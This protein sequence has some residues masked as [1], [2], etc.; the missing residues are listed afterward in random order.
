M[1]EEINTEDLINTI[2]ALGRDWGVEA[3]DLRNFRRWYRFYQ[4]LE[5]PEL[6]SEGETD[7]LVQD[8]DAAFEAMERDS[9]KD[10]NYPLE[11]LPAAPAERLRLQAAQSERYEQ[12]PDY[13]ML[14]K[15]FYNAFIFPL[16]QDLFIARTCQSL[17]IS[18]VAIGVQKKTR[19]IPVGAYSLSR[20]EATLG[21]VTAAFA[22][23]GN[24]LFTDIFSPD[25]FTGS[26]TQGSQGQRR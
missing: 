20:A 19:T 18:Q 1:A 24:L 3:D 10:P 12:H 22:E 16:E 5:T 21:Q 25:D 17:E 26:P 7:R 8:E 6:E 13:Y 9:Y 11:S 2:L 4:Q 14:L 23:L 15:S